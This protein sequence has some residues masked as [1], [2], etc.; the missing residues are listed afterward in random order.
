MVEYTPITIT[1]PL[2]HDPLSTFGQAG[3][4]CL[5][6]NYDDPYTTSLHY[7]IKAFIKINFDCKAMANKYNAST[8]TVNR[9]SD[10]YCIVFSKR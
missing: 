2:A 8:T 7:R 4:G 1:V 5:P 6:Y 9:I 3:P 10:S